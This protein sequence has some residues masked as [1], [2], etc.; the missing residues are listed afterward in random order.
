MVRPRV[1]RTSA[2]ALNCAHVSGEPAGSVWRAAFDEAQRLWPSVVLPFEAFQAHAEKVTGGNLPEG[3][4]EAELFLACACGMGD[5]RALTILEEQYLLPARGSLQRLDA[6]PE[7]IDD[8][9]QEFRTKLLVGDNPRIMNYGGRGPLLAWIRVAVTRTA[10]D[11]LRATKPHVDIDAADADVLRH[12]DLTPEVQMLREAYRDAFKDAL[13]TTLA[14]LSAKDRNLL[15]RH[16]VD[17]LTLDEIAAPYGVHPAT[18]ARRL[19]GLREEIAQSVRRR[20]AAS[21]REA[22]GSTSLESVAYAI[23][24]EV[25]LSLAPLLAS[26]QTVVEKPVTERPGRR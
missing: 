19:A 1:D 18:I 6:R 16:L 15:R 3:G 22:G 20:L 25:D 17:H 21:H 10:I 8:V 2:A 7:F 26:A 5:R 24:S 9:M 11:L 12:A 13:G 4:Q 23:R 14:D